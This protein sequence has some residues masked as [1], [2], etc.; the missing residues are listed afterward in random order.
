MNTN[1]KSDVVF[2]VLILT[3]GRADHMKTFQS[4]RRSNYSGPIKFVIDD[5]DKQADR[6]RQN[7][8]D[9][10]VIVFNKAEIAKTFDEADN[11]QERRAIIYARNASFQIAK[12]LGWTHF[13]QLDDDYSQF[14]W[15]FDNELRYDRSTT[16]RNLDR[17]FAAMVEFVK[18]TPTLTLAMAQGGD[19][20]G[21]GKSGYA[22]AIVIAKGFKRKAMNTF[23]FAVDNPCQF[24]SRVN[25]DVCTY[26]WRGSQ[27]DLFFTI[28]Q[29]GIVQCQTQKTS[30][31]MT[32]LYQMYGTYVKSFYSVMRMPSCVRISVLA[33]KHKRLHHEVSWSNC[34]PAIMHERWKKKV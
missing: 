32:D 5:E 34:V 28:N 22:D 3:H 1:P 11:F 10:N 26:T 14:A 25:E 30:G 15:T 27:G 19:L 8:G 6:Y 12:D 18:T 23:V 29:V 2:G 33:S 7:F 4:L 24:V 17:I 20:M 31:G 9:E 21:G 13:I 16:V